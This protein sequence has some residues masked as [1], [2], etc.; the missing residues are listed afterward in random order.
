MSNENNPSLDL[1]IIYVDLHQNDLN[2]LLFR[3]WNTLSTS[4]KAV[5]EK[6]SDERDGFDVGRAKSGERPVSKCRNASKF[7]IQTMIS[8]VRLL[9]EGIALFIYL[10]I[11]LFNLFF[12]SFQSPIELD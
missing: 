9:D 10:F 3:Q 4:E 12:M 11:Y 2:V 1:L 7:Y 5:Y 8:Q 6:M